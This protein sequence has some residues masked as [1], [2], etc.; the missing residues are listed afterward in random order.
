[1]G[2]SI[3]I[4]CADVM[5]ISGVAE[6]SSMLQEIGNGFTVTF[7]AEGVERIDTSTLQL[8]TSFIRDAS[9]RD[10]SVEWKNPS[11]ALI[12]SARLLGLVE[13]LHLADV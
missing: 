6:L 3:K 1:M 12:N 13:H 10:I 5:D 4:D 11:A 7:K 9:T 2:K 8:L